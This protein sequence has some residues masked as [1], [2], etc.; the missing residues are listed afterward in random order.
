[1]V[2]KAINKKTMTK[3]MIIK[4]KKMMK[5]IKKIMIVAIVMTTM[6]MTQMEVS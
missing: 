5:K 6:M 2:N 1:M 4:I 3:K